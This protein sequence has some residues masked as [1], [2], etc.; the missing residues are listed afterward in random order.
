MICLNSY[1]ELDQSDDPVGVLSWGPGNVVPGYDTVACGN[2]ALYY[3]TRRGGWASFLIE[4]LVKR[5]DDYAWS[6]YKK[7][8]PSTEGYGRGETVYL[9]EIQPR[10]EL[11]T[12]LLTDEQSRVLAEDLLSSPCVYLHLLADDEIYPITITNT[13]TE[14]KTY[15]ANKKKRVSYQITATAAN[16][17]IRR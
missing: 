8:N 16:K 12:S 13:N 11:N 6:K 15:R 9:N 7:Y 3:K 5:Y 1:T 10:W 4:G 2:A 17:R 14:Y